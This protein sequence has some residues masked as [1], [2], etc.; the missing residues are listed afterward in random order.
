MKILKIY[1]DKIKYI[2]TKLF[3]DFKKFFTV[4]AEAFHPMYE[5][6]MPRITEDENR[7][8]DHSS[9]SKESNSEVKPDVVSSKIPF[10]IKAE[11]EAKNKEIAELKA[12]L[13]TVEKEVLETEKY[14]KAISRIRSA[15]SLNS[16]IK[17]VGRPTKDR[18]KRTVK[19]DTT[20][21]VIYEY[22]KEIE[23][24]EGDF[25]SLINTSLHSFFRE[26]YPSA[27]SIYERVLEERDI[28]NS[29]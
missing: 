15:V 19:I 25:S 16:P 21:L 26:K 6:W 20:V 18:I 12:K 1:K 27:Y 22:A 7:S 2:R 3:I 4:V 9:E 10:A 13:K 23:L 17:K 28:S 5:S 8:M 14:Q 11:I 24:I 29:I